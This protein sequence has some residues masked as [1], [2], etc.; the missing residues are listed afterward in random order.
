MKRHHGTSRDRPSPLDWKYRPRTSVARRLP[1]V[2]DLRRHCPPVYDQLHL[3]SCSA[4]ALACA[5]RFDELEEGRR[6]L[7][8]P[9]RLFIYFNERLVAGVVDQDASVSLR[10]GYRTIAKFGSCPE[11]MW[12]YQV[13]RFRRQ[14]TPRCYRAG[15][16]HEAVEYYRIRRAL[17]H[18]RTCLAEEYPFVFGLAVHKSMLS[19]QVKRT[20]LIPVPRRGDH[21]VGGHAVLAVGYDHPRRVFIIR[22]SW[23]HDWGHDGYAC[24][25]Y[26]FMRSS[27]LS[28]DFWTMRRVS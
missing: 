14:P 21:M 27:A 19:R 22:N 28:W 16:R 7:P 12:P 15:R 13:R 18:L 5:L 11:P 26:E 4:N 8:E 9:S 23:G 1:D 3:N 6:S 10:D 20:G 25:P 17:S 2:V 24:L